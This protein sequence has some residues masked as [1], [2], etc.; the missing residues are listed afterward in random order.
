[1]RIP[2]AWD[3][4]TFD[5]FVVLLNLQI[6]EDLGEALRAQT[7]GNSSGGLGHG[8]Y[9]LKAGAGLAMAAAGAGDGGE[10]DRDSEKLLEVRPSAFVTECAR[11]PWHTPASALQIQASLFVSFLR[12]RPLQRNAPSFFLGVTSSLG[13]SRVPCWSRAHNWH[14]H[15]SFHIW[16]RIGASRD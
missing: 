12:G 9:S 11:M 6:G 16:S 1:M 8:V 5:P 15:A 2:A 7:D 14:K 3:T 13:V 10:L 4:C